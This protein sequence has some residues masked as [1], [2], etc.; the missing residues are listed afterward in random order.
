MTTK[1][2]YSD[3]IETVIPQSLLDDAVGWIARYLEPEEVFSELKLEKW[4]EASGFIEEVKDE[5][6]HTTRNSDST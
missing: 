2:E 4:A 6:N 1:S 5:A 3:F